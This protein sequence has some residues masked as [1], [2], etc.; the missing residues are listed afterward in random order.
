LPYGGHPTT[1][2]DDGPSCSPASPR[3][4]D[5]WV[6]RP[7]LTRA[8]AVLLLLLVAVLAPPSLIATPFE[9]RVVDQDTG[10]GLPVHLATDKRHPS[11]HTER[12]HLLVGAVADGAVRPLRGV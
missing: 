9:L 6:D 7:S 5:A 8:T 3:G 11:R 4:Y 12:V 2:T 1:A 10:V